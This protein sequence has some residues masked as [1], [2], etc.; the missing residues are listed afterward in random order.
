MNTNIVLSGL[1]LGSLVLFLFVYLR[2]VKRWVNFRNLRNKAL[3][4]KDETKTKELDLMVYNVDRRLHR[5]ECWFFGYIVVIVVIAY[6]C[7]VDVINLIR[8]ALCF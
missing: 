3:T 7:G 6:L 2:T 1:L 8:T 4:D 5:I